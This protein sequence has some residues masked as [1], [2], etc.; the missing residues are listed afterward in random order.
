MAVTAATAGAAI[1]LQ[2]QLQHIAPLLLLLLGSRAGLGKCENYESYIK[3]D[4][5]AVRGRFRGR[6]QIV[7]GWLAGWLDGWMDELDSLINS[8]VI[9]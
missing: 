3:V 1:V 4:W 9:D 6:R 7:P 5:E 2:L 8:S